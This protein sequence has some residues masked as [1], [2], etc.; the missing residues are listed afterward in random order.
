MLAANAA[1]AIWIWPDYLAYFNVIAGGPRQGYRWL[2]DSSIDWGQDL[3]A[4]ASWLA[5][6]PDDARDPQRVYLS[7]FGV[8]KPD[9][10]DIRAELLPS[11]GIVRRP[12]HCTA[13]R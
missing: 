9:Y 4:L 12:G 6:H 3:K 7:Y 8:A 2:V 11:K 5:A 1:E 10:F 13:P